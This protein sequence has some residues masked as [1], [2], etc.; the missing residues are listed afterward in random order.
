MRGTSRYR[1]MLVGALLVVSSSA[2]TT[3][4]AEPG[5]PDEEDG[6]SGAPTSGR[7][8]LTPL[9]APMRVGDARWAQGNVP[10][11]VP[12]PDVELPSLLGDLP[13]RALVS[14]YVPRP[15]LGFTDEAVE[16]YGADGRWRRLNLGDLEL[17]ED[18]WDGDDTLGAGALSPDGRR[19]AGSMYDGMF[20]VD[21][22][23][24]T[25][26]VLDSVKDAGAGVASFVWS[27]DSDE[28]VLV[29][30]GKSTRVSVPD[31]DVRPFPQPGNGPRLL[32]DGGWVECEQERRVVTQCNTYGPDADLTDEQPIPPDLRHRWSGPWVEPLAVAS[33]SVFYEVAKNLYGNLRTDSEVLRTDAAFA[34]NS[35]L[36]LPAG[37]DINSVDNAISDNVLGLS[38]LNHRLLLAWVVDDRAVVKVM[39]PGIGMMDT[40]QD[41]WDISYAQDLVNIGS[42]PS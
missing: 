13:G 33:G 24:G 5:P 21:L 38:A 37:S 30:D 7:S 42:P 14:S 22:S 19:W 10:R 3:G 29:L 28:L 4:V 17:P 31:L 25:T 12:E 20:L 1:P 23:D 26:T 40:A 32:A 16:F 36:V 27:P 41:A 8:E 15:A 34:A 11:S 18:G 35:R 6:P 2:C 39:R 9:T